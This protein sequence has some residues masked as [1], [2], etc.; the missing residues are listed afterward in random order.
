M[1]DAQTVAAGKVGIMYVL[2]A[3]NLGNGKKMGGKAYSTAN[4]GSCW[5]G[6]SY[7]MGSDGFGR[8]VAQA[9]TGGPGPFTVVSA[10]VAPGPGNTLYTRFGDWFGWACWGLAFLGLVGACIPAARRG[11]GTPAQAADQTRVPSLA[12]YGG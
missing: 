8:V 1:P 7:Y 12:G 2:N 3:D 11:G 9:H 10:D 6:P 5:C 4:V